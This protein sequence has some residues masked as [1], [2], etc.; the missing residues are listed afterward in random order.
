M[1][2]LP[3]VSQLEHQDNDKNNKVE[4][5]KNGNRKLNGSRNHVQNY[6]ATKVQSKVILKIKQAKPNELQIKASFTD[7]EGG[8]VKEMSLTFETEMQRSSLICKKTYSDLYFDM[9]SLKMEE[10]SS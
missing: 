10:G 8:E 2:K 5:S 9:I 7:S 3:R 1:I 4:K 6:Q